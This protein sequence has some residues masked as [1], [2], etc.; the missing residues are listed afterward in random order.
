MKV[1]A[2]L[3]VLDTDPEHKKL[4]DLLTSTEDAKTSFYVIG[5]D[6]KSIAGTEEWLR[7]FIGPAR[8][9]VFPFTFEDDFAAA[10][11][12]TLSRVPEDCEWW[13][14]IDSDDTL[15]SVSGKS[16][17]EFCESI[18]A[19][20]SA[21]FCNY[22]YDKD[23]YGNST[24]ILTRGRFYRSVVPWEWRGRVHEDVYPPK[25]RDWPE[26]G[27]AR[28]ED[29]LWVHNTE[30]RESAGE[31]NFRLLERAISENPEDA[32]NWYYLGNQHFA[33]HDWQKSILAFDRYL[34]LSNWTEQ[35]WDALI[36][37]AIAY[38]SLGLL[39]EAIV[40]DT[41][42]MLL[43]P[44]WADSYFGLGESYTRKE[45]WDK[46]IHFGELGLQRVATGDGIP[47]PVVF[48]NTN[49]YDHNPYRWLAVA[50]FNTGQN[51]KALAALE[52]AAKSRPEPELLRQVE[53]MKWAMARQQIVAQGLNLA[54]GLLRRNEPLKAKTILENLPAGALDESPSA[55]TA[56]REASRRVAHLYDK[57][58]YKNLYFEQEE[59]ID[60]LAVLEHGEQAYP[61]MAWVV[62][63][64]KAAGAKRVLDMGVG[65]AVSSFMYAKAGIQVVGIDVD[66][67]RVRDA[68][69]NAVKAGFLATKEVG[70]GEDGD[71][72]DVVTVPDISYDSPVQ[73]HYC[74]ADELSDKI[75]ELGPYDAVVCAEV[76]EHVKDPELLLA[77]C[78]RASKRVIITTPDGAYDGPQEHNPSH[79]FVWSQRELA[80]LIVPRGKVV[81]LHKVE[82]PF[83]GDQGNLMVE[84]LAGEAVTGAPVTIWC[85]NTGQDWTPDSIREGG[86]GGSETAVIRVAE[87][88]AKMGKR[89]T[90]YA[91]CEGIWNGV[92]YAKSRDFRPIPCETFISWRT[93]GPI[94]QMADFAER[95]YVWAH[96]IHFGEASEEQLRGVTV[97]ALSAWHKK[98]MQAKYPTA[99]I[100]VLGNGIDPERFDK[101]AK[102]QRY[103]LIYAQSPDRG[104]DVVL[105]L[106]PKIRDRY[107]DA[108]LHVFYGFDMARALNPQFIAFIEEKAE[109]PGVF[110]HGRV[111]QQTLAEEYLKSDVLLYPAT[112]PNGQPFDE[113][114][115]ISVVEAQA[116]GCVPITPAHGA[117]AETNKCGIVVHDAEPQDLLDALFDF[118]QMPRKV[119]DEY[120]QMGHLWA[121]EQTW[122]KVARGWPAESR[123]PVLA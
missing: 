82:H 64:L 115:C 46:A 32:R 9:D 36:R 111:D 33:V 73:F 53:H 67:R 77:Q 68:N 118:W 57:A 94:T 99:D 52:R 41:K 26:L 56:H 37:Q 65:N 59:S 58:A 86:I 112:M 19:D 17:V 43:L 66:I 44:K 51:D 121:T 3:I 87:E 14:W 2:C 102:R 16:V 54:A 22:D 97:V 31:R 21:V 84:Y 29:F 80:R 74:D 20:V 8:C 122:E 76:I 81:S 114:Y 18:P 15:Q 75:L 49:A 70:L 110:L 117:L 30:G 78:E 123:E 5:V 79:V 25:G 72:E 40:C 11:Q 63:R 28:S 13:Y 50:Y 34:S 107:P 35:K 6:S 4:A 92:R 27:L 113:T 93:I 45:D 120:R 88:F 100:I 116:A 10:R 12:Q 55:Q 60:P 83:P 96:D 101:E 7:D 62:R 38:R 89:V 90:V 71:D 108:E 104:L 103:R 24:T 106:F 109:Q 23:Q 85:P 98:F 39:D 47:D 91:E 61:R 119:Q 95:R 42:A 1:A 105:N 69:W 48:I